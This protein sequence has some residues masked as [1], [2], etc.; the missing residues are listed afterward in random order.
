MQQTHATLYEACR[1]MR[2]CTEM[3]AKGGNNGEDGGERAA[4]KTNELIVKVIIQN[5]KK[6]V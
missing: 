5:E 1:A 4:T 6:A 3:Y 2:V